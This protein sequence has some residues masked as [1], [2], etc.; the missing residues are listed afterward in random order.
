[1]LVGSPTMKFTDRPPTACLLQYSY[2]LP[3]CMSA[4]AEGAVGG[5]MRVNEWKGECWYSYMG[6]LIK[7][8]VIVIKTKMSFD[9]AVWPKNMRKFFSQ[10]SI[11]F[12]S[13]SY[14]RIVPLLE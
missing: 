2:P 4:M 9:E 11:Y 12:V 14:H 6:T 10:S 3:V 1:M 13:W 8:G 5:V 7:G